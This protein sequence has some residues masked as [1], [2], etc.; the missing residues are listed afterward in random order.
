MGEVDRLIQDIRDIVNL[1]NVQDEQIKDSE[2]W[3]MLCSSMD[4]T[5]DTELAIEGYNQIKEPVVLNVNYLFLFGIL[6]A[7]YVQQDALRNLYLSFGFDYEFNDELKN[8][9]EIR[10]DSI[11]HPTKRHRPRRTSSFIGRPTIK[12]N[13]FIVTLTYPDN[14]KRPRKN[15]NIPELIETQ[16]KV[17]SHDLSALFG[18]IIN[19][20]K[21]I[22]DISSH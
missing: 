9:R 8:I 6:Q 16:R 5:E 18:N 17:I 10:N 20:Y 13:G 21:S 19:K 22:L 7:L 11:G 12:I 4:M 2:N 15:V 1:R 14:S 3:N